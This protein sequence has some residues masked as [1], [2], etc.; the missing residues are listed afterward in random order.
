MFDYTIIGGKYYRA[1][2]VLNTL[3]QLAA[4]S[5]RDIEKVWEGGLVLGWCIEIVRTPAHSPLHDDAQPTSTQQSG[6]FVADSVLMI[7]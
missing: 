5:G 4:E 6:V 3:Q 7:R 1:T 2:L